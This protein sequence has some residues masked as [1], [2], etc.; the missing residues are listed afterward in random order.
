M[1][2]YSAKDMPTTR[3][4][5]TGLFGEMCIVILQIAI[6]MYENKREE[7]GKGAST[8]MVE[9]PSSVQKIP[10][11]G[12]WSVGSGASLR[13]HRVSLPTGGEIRFT[14][15][16]SGDMCRG[17]H[18]AHGK[19]GDFFGTKS[20]PLFHAFPSKKSL[21]FFEKAQR[22]LDVTPLSPPF[23]LGFLA[24]RDNHGRLRLP[25][26]VIPRSSPSELLRGF[27]AS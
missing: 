12:G 6:Q 2:F 24:T 22:F 7:P 3:P 20:S 25:G 19:G 13:S 1:P 9:A 17:K 11:E 18:A 21:D 23:T 4:P 10:V 16:L 14:I 26:M 8:G 5:F 27:G 15:V